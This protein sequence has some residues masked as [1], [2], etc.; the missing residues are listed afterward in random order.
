MFNTRYLILILKLKSNI[1][2]IYS[3]S[4]TYSQYCRYSAGPPAS[5][6]RYFV[7][8]FSLRL[9]RSSVGRFNEGY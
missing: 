9:L 4:N 1:I 5:P 8:T 7:R 6:D 3:Y 2:V